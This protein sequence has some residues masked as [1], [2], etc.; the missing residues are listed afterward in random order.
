MPNF[1]GHWSRVGVYLGQV[2]FIFNQRKIKFKLILYNKTS[3]VKVF[4]VKMLEI[5]FRIQL[6]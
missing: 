4:S 5:H 2:N 1:S 6:E 3:K